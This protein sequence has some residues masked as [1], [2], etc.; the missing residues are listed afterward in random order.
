MSGTFMSPA[1]II[2]GKDPLASKQSNELL[3]ASSGFMSLPGGR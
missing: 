2:L 3:R 1:I